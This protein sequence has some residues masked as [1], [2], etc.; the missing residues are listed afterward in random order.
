MVFTIP[1]WILVLAGVFITLLVLPGTFHFGRLW[2]D[3]HYLFYSIPM[4]L[5]GY[6]ALWLAQFERMQWMLLNSPR[7]VKLHGEA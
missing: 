5:V 1:G 7:L 2:M 6:Q 4:I 3:Y